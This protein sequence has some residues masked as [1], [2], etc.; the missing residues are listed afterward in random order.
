MV[1]QRD[2]W[3]EFLGPSARLRRVPAFQANIDEG[4]D[5]WYHRGNF[6]AFGGWQ[7]DGLGLVS[8]IIIGVHFT[9]LSVRQ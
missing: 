2:S 8:D 7:F 6:G 9:E 4:A 1:K 5:L 3:T